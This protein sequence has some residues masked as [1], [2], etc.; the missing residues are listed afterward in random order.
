MSAQSPNHSMR[1]T[2]K[3]SALILGILT[4]PLVQATPSSLL[5]TLGLQAGQSYGLAKTQLI[6]KGWKVD[7][8]YAPAREAGEIAPYGFKEVV[9]GNGWHAVCSARFLRNDQEIMLTLRPKKILVVEG[10]WDDS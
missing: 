6:A 9:C 8:T 7:S 2:A 10:A 1:T 4:L 5:K 3:I